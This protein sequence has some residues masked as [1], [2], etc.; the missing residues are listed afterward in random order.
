MY[1][2]ICT[3]SY[4]YVNFKLMFSSLL[5]V[6]VQTSKLQLPTLMLQKNS[7]RELVPVLT[8]EFKLVCRLGQL[9]E[10]RHGFS[11]NLENTQTT[12]KWWNFR[13][14]PGHFLD[15][16]DIIIL[17]SVNSNNSE[18]YKISNGTVTFTFVS[19]NSNENICST[20]TTRTF[21][22]VSATS[23]HIRFF[24]FFS[25]SFSTVLLFFWLCAVD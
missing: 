16:V 18:C 9:T 13:N 3:R 8:P 24:L 11:R 10:I 4:I 17:Q 21:R 22:T 15:I 14:A 12:K 20:L 23:E 1:V 25:F 2:H 6:D 19:Y 5:V 7:K